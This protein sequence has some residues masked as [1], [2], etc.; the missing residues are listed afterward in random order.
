[1]NEESSL[2]RLLASLPPGDVPDDTGIDR[3]LAECWDD[4]CGSD[5]GGMEAY[6]LLRY[7]ERAVWTPPVLSF[8]IER[9]GGLACGSTRAELQHWSV[10]LDKNEAQIIKEGYRQKTPMDP[11][12]P[13]KATATEIARL[14]LAGQED[15]RLD[16]QANGTVKVL[17]RKIYPEGS[18]YK[19]TVEGRRRRLCQYIETSLLG[20]G[21]AKQGW[22]VFSPPMS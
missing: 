12:K 2:Q 20:Y 17:A 11:R 14:I 18:G 5:D 19:R 16:R 21:W 22:N 6:K 15:E 8:V 4:F 1:M 7:M 3:L 10:N 9:H 13:V